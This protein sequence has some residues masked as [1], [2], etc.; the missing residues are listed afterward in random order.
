LNI[1][2]DL[3]NNSNLSVNT[4]VGVRRDKSSHRILDITPRQ[5]GAAINT[6]DASLSWMSMTDE[7]RVEAHKYR[8][9][10]YENRADYEEQHHN[11]NTSV[12]ADLENAA[13]DYFFAG[14]VKAAEIS[15]GT[16]GPLNLR[17]TDA[18]PHGAD[19]NWRRIA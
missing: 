6:G 3:F 16:C 7:Q 19:T 14:N 8:A 15:S 10:A 4:L 12:R 18:F 2:I 1:V 11:D 5:L 9:V 17:Q 13:K